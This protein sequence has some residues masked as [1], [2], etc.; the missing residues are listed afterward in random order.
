MFEANAIE[1]IQ[2]NDINNPAAIPAAPAAMPANTGAAISQQ[3]LSPY[4]IDMHLMQLCEQLQKSNLLPDALRSTKDHDKT[5]D[6]YLICS[7]GISLGLTPQQAIFGIYC[8]P[9]G[10]PALYTKT[11]RA[12]ALQHGCTLTEEFD[13]QT[14]TAICHVYRDGHDYVG[15]YSV[16]DAINARCMVINPQ[17]GMAEGT[18]SK[19]G[20]ATVWKMAPMQMLRIRAQ[21]HA[22]DLACADYFMGLESKEF[23]DDFAEFTYA[24]APAMPAA[25]PTLPAKRGRKKK[26]DS[27]LLGAQPDLMGALIPEAQTQPDFVDFNENLM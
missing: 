19:S 27:D 18:M 7:M 2:L 10:A 12:I 13:S 22:L 16:Q 17:T 20:K 4:Q 14:N 15:T 3:T 24:D 5:I 1:P 21:S 26:D 25:A 23:N 11:K 6:L 9:G 8:I